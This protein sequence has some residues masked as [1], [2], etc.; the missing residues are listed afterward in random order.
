MIDLAGSDRQ[1]RA[2]A[3][4]RLWVL[5]AAAAAVFVA[6]NAH[7]IYVATVSQPACV[8][9]LKQGE[10]DAARGQFSAARSACSPPAAVNAGH[11]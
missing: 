10:G 11:S 1:P 6:A 2:R 5:L 9:H 8:A 4:I 7:L 3:M